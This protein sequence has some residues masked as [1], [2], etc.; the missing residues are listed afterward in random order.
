MSAVPE[1]RIEVVREP[2]IDPATNAAIMRLQTRAFPKTECFA[3]TRHYRHIARSGDFR[4][5]AYSGDTAVGQVTLLWGAARGEGGTLRLA[6]IGNVCSDPDYRG[7]HAASICLEHALKVARQEGGD[8]SLLFCGASLEKFYQRFGFA[9]VPNE[10]FFTHADGEI[11]RRD[12]RDIRM[13]KMLTDR[14]WPM[15]ALYLDTEDF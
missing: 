8:G 3:W 10:V 7:T 2:D 13:G 6:C 1:I 9:I 11:F 5:L 4:V 12:H 14:P 15:G